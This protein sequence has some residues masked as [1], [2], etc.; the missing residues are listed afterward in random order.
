MTQNAMTIQT[1]PLPWRDKI[2][3]DACMHVCVVAEPPSPSPPKSGQLNN[4]FTAERRDTLSS[5][6]MHEGV[7]M[8]AIGL[9][10]RFLAK[11]KR[12]TSTVE[13]RA[14]LVNVRY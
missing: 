9:A 2:L 5:V 13:R 8:Q 4:L 14:C 11:P 6:H 1:S 3:G 10:V 12:R 7:A